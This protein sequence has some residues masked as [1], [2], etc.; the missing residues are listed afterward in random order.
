MLANA[1][2]SISVA[3]NA[4][5]SRQDISVEDLRPGEAVDYVLIRLHELKNEGLPELRV[6]VGYGRHGLES[7]A[8]IMSAMKKWVVYSFYDCTKISAVTHQC[9]A[10]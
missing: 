8:L 2:V 5:L 6:D 4:G 1:N 7:R 9:V 3:H 10:I